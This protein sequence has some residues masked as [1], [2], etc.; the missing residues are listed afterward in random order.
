[1]ITAILTAYYKER[2]QNISKIIYSLKSGAVIPSSIYLFNNNKDLKFNFKDV[3]TINSD[4]NLGAGIRFFLA[5]GIKS[6]Y[7]FFIDDD[8]T[9]QKE[10]LKNFLK[11]ADKSCCLG[12]NGKII[13]DKYSKAP[14]VWGSTLKK[15]L[16][17]DVLVGAGGLFCSYNA[18][19][20]MAICESMYDGTSDNGR[21]SD[22]VLSMA[23]KP[24]VIPFDGKSGIIKLSEGNV[25]FVTNKNHAESRDNAFDK[26]KE[27]LIK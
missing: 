23:N 15:P 26:I 3:N 5:M 27:L 13:K 19:V 14:S 22:I 16:D 7:Y 2:Y 6:K 20:K 18:L 4:K 17:V 8:R 21:N 25:G 10:T 24:K 12:L 1:M 9:V 11:Y